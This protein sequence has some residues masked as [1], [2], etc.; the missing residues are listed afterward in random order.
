MTG[1]VPSIF[2]DDFSL[3]E[4]TELTTIMQ[5]WIERLQQVIDTNG[6]YT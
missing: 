6:E 3:I 1:V 4:P 5:A 2:T